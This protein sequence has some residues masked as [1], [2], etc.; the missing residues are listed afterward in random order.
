M[1]GR[2]LLCTSIEKPVLQVT[3][4]K[5]DCNKKNKELGITLGIKVAPTFLLYKDNELIETIKGAKVDALNAAI[6]THM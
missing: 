5:F 4:Y 1:H 6:E 3:F 2:F